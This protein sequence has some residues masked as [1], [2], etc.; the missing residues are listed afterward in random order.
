MK[1]MKRSSMQSRAIKHWRRAWS[2]LEAFN[3]P[4]PSKQGKRYSIV[5]VNHANPHSWRPPHFVRDRRPEEHA[6]IREKHHILVEGEDIP[7]PIEHFVDMK[8]PE[9]IVQFL[10][11]NRIIS[12]T[13]IQLQGIP[14]A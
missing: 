1:R 7:P 8:I 3:T 9:P 12:P 10:K 14:A 13:P 5:S 11:T 2:L 6:R 4:S